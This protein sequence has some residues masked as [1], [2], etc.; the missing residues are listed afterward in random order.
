MAKVTTPLNATQ[1]KNAKA[2]LKDMTLFDGGGLA[3]IV[4]VNG[5]KLWRFRYTQPITKKRAMISF[6]SWPEVSLADA[7]K[8][9]DEAR[10]L[11]AT[12]ID[13]LQYRNKLQQSQQQKFKN[14]LEIIAY[15]WFVIKKTRITPDYADDVWRSFKLHVFPKLGNYPISQVTAPLTI[16][17]LRPLS[18]LKKPQF[19]TI[20]RVCQRL[21]E[22]MTFAVNTGVIH[23][24][25]LTGINAAF[26]KPKKKHLP[27][28]TPDELPKFMTDLK[29]ASIKPITYQ[30]ILWQLHTMVRP[31]EAAG[32]RWDEIKFD[33]KEWHIPG[34]RMK[35]K[36]A[37]VVPLSHQLLHLLETMKQI[38]GKREHIFPNSVNPRRSA[39]NQSVNMA[40]KRMGYAGKLV[41]HGLRSIA[42]T[43][44]NENEFPFDV[45]ESA[46][47][48]IDRNEVRSAYN[49]AQY[50]D[51]RRKM[52]QWWS[53]HI[54]HCSEGNMNISCGKTLSLFN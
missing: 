18:K 39:N 28:I 15:N 31:S 30:M 42:S 36:R 47:A 37:H 35:N 48:H 25:P 1:I 6:G 53:N 34:K 26:E 22:V 49:R 9:R 5:S 54:E 44:L 51:Q 20:K 13:P 7:R 38:S 2:V 43:T 46:L 16:E 19:E 33:T 23:A 21:N 27:T 41:A 45:I 40:I 52:M 4:K 10:K 8:K 3:I 11:I 17:A 24:N 14:T 32:A 50:L 29:S 12:E